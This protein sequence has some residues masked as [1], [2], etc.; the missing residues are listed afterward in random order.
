MAAL[1][2]AQKASIEERG[3]ATGTGAATGGAATGTQG[4]NG[5]TALWG[6]RQPGNGGD[7][8]RPVRFYN[9]VSPVGFLPVGFFARSIWPSTPEEAVIDPAMLRDDAE[10]ILRATVSDNALSRTDA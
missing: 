10:A 1:A 2:D 9:A 6:R 3:A 4:G 7:G 8:R 5:D